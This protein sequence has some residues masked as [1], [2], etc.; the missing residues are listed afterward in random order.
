VWL[1]RPISGGGWAKHRSYSHLDSNNALTRGNASPGRMRVSR[2]APPLRPKF[3]SA[4]AALRHDGHISIDA[5]PGRPSKE[6]APL[7]E[8]TH[9]KVKTALD[10]TRLLILGAQI[11]LGFHLNGAF[12]AVFADL[13]TVARAFH[14]ADA[15][16]PPRNFNCLPPFIE[17]LGYR[18]HSY[19]A[20][21]HPL[22]IFP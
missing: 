6:A 22:Q 20:S 19:R 15:R 11:L 4:P 16:W 2:F 1:R 12:R 21:Q 14:A 18:L 8:S 13:S 17:W 9:R 10:E 5:V 3:L 7:S